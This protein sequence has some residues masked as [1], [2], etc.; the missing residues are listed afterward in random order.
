MDLRLTHLHRFVY[1]HF[2]F[3]GVRQAVGMLAPVL[4]LGGLFNQYAVGLAATFGALC[5][6]II[7]Q[8]GPHWHRRNEML[9][10]SLLG[11]ATVALTGIASSHP[12]AIWLA[13]IAQCF[14][15]SMFSVFGRKGSQIGFACLLLMT[16]TMH[17]PLTMNEAAVHAAATLGGGLFYLLFSTLVS[18][19]SNLR[20]EQQ[21]LSLALFATAEYV[22]ARAAF[23]DVDNDLEDCYRTMI[24]RQSAMTEKHQAARDMVLRVLPRGAGPG[25]RRRIMLWN[26]FVDM[27]AL[28]DT[29]I[30]THTDYATLRRALREADVLLFA[31]DALRKMSLELEHVALAVSRNR[32][33]EHRTSVKAELRAIEYELEQLR[34]QGWPER[35]PE[36]YA[37]LVQVQRRLRNAARVVDRLY[38]HTRAAA[39]ALPQGRL[40]LD[41]SLSRFLSRQEFR[42]GM[43]TSNL[44]LDSPHCRFALRVTLAA[45][46]AMTLTAFVPTLQPHGYWIVL[47][48]LIIMKPGFALTRQRN[49]WRLLGT[50]LGCALAVGA[51]ELTDE[52]GALFAIMVAACIMGNSLL[53]VNYMASSIFNTLFVLL[54]FHFISPGTLAV[55]GERAIDTI[56][57]CAIALACS[58]VLP[59]WEYRYMAPLARAAL[60][61]NRQYLR[62]GLRY[63]AVMQ[64]RHAAS[65]PGVSAAPAQAGPGDF[66][67]QAPADVQSADFAFQLARKNVHVA[68]GNM[69]EAFYR[70]MNEPRS[71]QRHVPEVNNLLIQNHI[72]ASQIAATVPL[73]ADLPATP[74][75]I[76][77]TLEQVQA[78]LDEEAL[79]GT[80][81]PVA[82][83]TDGDLA[84]LAYPV[85]QMAKAA[86]LIRNELGT[87]E[88]ADGPVPPPRAKAA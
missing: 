18:R 68:F 1:S 25:D 26:L 54:A 77:K 10:G 80:L 72:L 30:A 41:K 76:G 84:A 21:A 22:A 32:R 44:R 64:A 11:T 51:F 61:A 17:A 66:A 85:R 8:P 47:T 35:D 57:G 65:E 19:L 60:S 79:P 74:P 2:F 13:V 9:G 31:R 50:L 78:L 56:V 24:R 75:G 62:A 4:L 28:L 48:I 73:L 3:G 39:D 40:R 86:Q 34:Q 83:E 82:I 87:L 36:V 49:G 88:A 33:A 29:L 5:V 23:Y 71:R 81:E 67:A 27:I 58:Y 70:M 15:F 6:A 43:I 69:A 46:I 20:E 37:L 45:S 53:L 55:V 63:A 16:L 59:W 7:D 12:V 42:L 14:A 38:E 52:P